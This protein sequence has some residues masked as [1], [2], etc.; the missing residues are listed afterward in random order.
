[1]RSLENNSFR[2]IKDNFLRT[3][4]ITVVLIILS[5]SLIYFDTTRKTF[6]DTRATIRDLILTIAS[7]I[8]SPAVLIEKGL[9][10]IREINNLYDELKDYKEE[11]SLSSDIF[12]ELSVLRQKVEIYENDLKFI[13]DN[14]FKSITVE[15]F[16]DT[17]NRYFSSILLKAGKNSG[18][19]ENN[20]IVSSRGLVGRVTE[21]GNK[22]S[23]GLLL[24]DISSRV[25]V[26]ISSS[27]IQG[28]LIGQNLNRPKINY[29]K[30]LNDIKV[31]DLVVT[32]GKGGIFP[33]NLVVGSVAIL[34][35]KNQ[36][37]EVDLIVNPKTLSRVRI[38]NYQIENRVE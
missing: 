14:E 4:I 17:S 20:T 33:S 8:A 25:P 12:Q 18:V 29:I 11:Q 22:V 3:T 16:A 36:H 1:V 2:F 27:E 9:Y 10:S 35:K 21:I 37:I 6:S 24:S 19:S 31:G 28:I 34:D 7:T 38:I 15:I 32:S 26:S 23:R 13:K 30:N 5:L